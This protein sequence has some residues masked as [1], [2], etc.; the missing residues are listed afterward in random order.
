ML[1]NWPKTQSEYVVGQT[2]SA[3][4]LN[5]GKLYSSASLYQHAF[6]TGETASNIVHA[7]GSWHEIPFMKEHKAAEA[8][9]R[10]KDRIEI[11]PRVSG[12]L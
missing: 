11:I 10:G 8:S 7:A 4:A 12:L 1:S 2:F 3:L 6:Y 9:E 5:R